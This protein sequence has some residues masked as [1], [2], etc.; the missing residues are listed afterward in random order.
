MVHLIS[1]D[2]IGH[3]RPSAYEAVESVI[4]SEAESFR[5][6]LYSQGLVETT[7]SASWWSDQVKTAIDDGDK[8][9]V[10]RVTAESFGWLPKSIWAW[11]AERV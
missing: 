8:L 3:E 9:F 4:E 5:R 1:Y 7:H 10:C 6:P 11:L 2:L